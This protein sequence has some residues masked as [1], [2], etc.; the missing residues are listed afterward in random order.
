MTVGDFLGDA[1]TARLAAINQLNN[2]L[3][4]ANQHQCQRGPGE[5]G[6]S[7]G[8][9]WRSLVDGLVRSSNWQHT[10]EA[11]VLYLAGVAAEALLQNADKSGPPK[12]VRGKIPDKIRAGGYEPRTRIAEA[13][14]RKYF[15]QRKLEEELSEFLE[16]NDPVELADLIETA[17]AMAD[18]IG[19]SREGLERLRVEKLH[20][21]GGFDAGIV[22]EGNDPPATETDREGSNE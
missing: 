6:E 1:G 5:S 18:A 17:F 20:D 10:G 8:T 11:G 12:I 19:V 13:E 16:S 7:C 2:A 21:L 3:R 15:L 4:Y 14:E 22:W 9:C